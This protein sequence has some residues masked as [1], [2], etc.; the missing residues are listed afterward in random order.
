[1]IALD[2]VVSSLP[3]DVPNAVE[4]RI[5]AMIDLADDL[6]IGMRLV[7]TDRNRPMQPNPLDRLAQKGF[8]RL[9]IPPC[10]QRKTDHL[11]FCID[12]APQVPPLAADADTDTDTD[13]SRSRFAWSIP[14][15][16]SGPGDTLSIG[17][18]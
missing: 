5:I 15:Q 10:R 17:P 13:V 11:T 1:M 2:Q 9:R 18:H 16:T 14:G 8:G 3:V 6:T 7:C 12:R 4:V